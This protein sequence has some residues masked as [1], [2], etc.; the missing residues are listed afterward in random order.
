MQVVVVVKVTVPV[1]VKSVDD[2]V[3]VVV[4]VVPVADAVAVPVVELRERGSTGLTP[5][6]GVGW[7][8]VGLC[9][10]VPCSNIRC[11]VEREGVV[12]VLDVV[13]IKVVREVGPAN[14]KVAEVIGRGGAAHVCIKPV[15][16]AVVV[17]VEGATDVIVQVVIVVDFTVD[18]AVL[19][20]V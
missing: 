7:V 4:N 12:L 13:V 19:I 20:T 17:L 3:V 14:G 10:A 2:T 6:V 11:S 8:G 18:G 16:D 15:V 9:G 1:D 5:R